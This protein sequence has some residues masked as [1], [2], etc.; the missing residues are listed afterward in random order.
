ME[1]EIAACKKGDFEAEKRMVR[2]FMPLF[3]SLAR[4]R[5]KDSAVINLCIEAGE[6]GLKKAIRKYRGFGG[7]EKFRIFAVEYIE[8]SI[9]E[10]F[11]EKKGFFARF[12]G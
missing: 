8:K 5:S 11:Q 6:R 3:T 10:V 1:N 4:K 9:D 12:F 2:N 7:S